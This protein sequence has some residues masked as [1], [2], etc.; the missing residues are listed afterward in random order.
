VD[1][2]GD[3]VREL[4]QLEE[5]GRGAERVAELAGVPRS[6]RDCAR[7]SSSRHSGPQAHL[8][9]AHNDLQEPNEP[10]FVMEEQ[11]SDLNQIRDRTTARRRL[12]SRPTKPLENLANEVGAGQ[13]KTS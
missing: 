9:L 5:E 10:T 1:R 4:E 11:F 3:Q 7:W 8:A 13:D 12:S 2:L 6:R